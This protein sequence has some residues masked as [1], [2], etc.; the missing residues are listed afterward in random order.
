[1]VPLAEELAFS[2][3]LIRKLVSSHF[4][5]PNA[6]RFTWL[7]FLGSLVLFG[8]L[9]SEWLLGTLARMIFTLAFYRRKLICDAVT[10]HSTA[11]AIAMLSLYV[12]ASRSWSVWS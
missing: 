3:Y 12:M 1:M 9:H 8:V 5:S 11:N 4:V 10:A 2:G 6:A 7:S